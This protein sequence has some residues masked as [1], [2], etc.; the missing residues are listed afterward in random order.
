MKDLHRKTHQTIK[1]VTNDVEDRFHF[2]TAISAIMELVNDIN[3]L[4][5]NN[6]VNHELQWSVIREA[7]ETVVLLLSPIVPHITEEMWRMLGHQISLL[8]VPWPS[9]KK[10]A[11]DVEK[12]LIVVQVNGK[13]R[14]RIEVPASYGNKELEAEAIKDEKIRHF[15][16]DKEVKK[17]IVVPNK[18]VNVVV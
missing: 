7:V 3:K 10:D 13:V 9:Y 16:G 14:S 8:E 6:E 18:L 11:L 2:N 4:L 17:V 12:R 15:I 5:S 1:K